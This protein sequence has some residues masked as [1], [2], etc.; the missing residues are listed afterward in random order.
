M[1][2]VSLHTHTQDEALAYEESRIA[3]RAALGPGKYNLSFMNSTRLQS[4]SHSELW[5]GNK[6][7]MRP[8]PSGKLKMLGSRC[9]CVFACVLACCLFGCFLVGVHGYGLHLHEHVCVC[10]YL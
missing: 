6:G 3:Q 9:V 7:T 4:I 2:R 1:K 10:V 8:G 5:A